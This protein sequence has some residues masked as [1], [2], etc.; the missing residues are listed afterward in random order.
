MHDQLLPQYI[1]LVANLATVQ[2]T[3]QVA[4]LAIRWLAQ[5][6]TT[7]TAQQAEQH[8]ATLLLGTWHN[9]WTTQLLTERK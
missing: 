8:A 9:K 3:Q 6:K 7:I 2:A 5:K 4:T 1:P